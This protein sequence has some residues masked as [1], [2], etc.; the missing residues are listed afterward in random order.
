M[1]RVTLAL[2]FALVAT[3]AFAQREPKNVQVL[4]ELT[5]GQLIRA[6]QFISA[7]LGV[8]CDFCHVRD[9]N[10]E[11]DAANDAK[12]EKKTARQMMHL[13]IDTNEKFFEGKTEVS[14]ET[15]HRGSPGPVSIPALPVSLPPRVAEQPKPAPLPPRDDVVAKYAKALGNVDQKALANVELKGTR[16]TAQGSGQ[17]D[18]VI[19]PGRKYR[20][21]G[22]TAQG[23]TINVV[24][25]ENGWV[26]DAKGTRPM[27]PNQLDTFLGVAEAYGMTL[28]ADIPADARVAGTTK[29]EDR[30]AY[31]MAVRTD[32]VRERLFFDAGT[33]LL[34]RRIRY[35]PTPIGNVPQQTDYSDY[36]D[37]N[38]MKVPFVVRV[39]TIDPRAGA[40][41]RYSEI[42]FNAKT[43][44]NQFE[45]PK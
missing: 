22:T 9:A 10:G 40:T 38:G 34:V 13:V 24:N 31:V 21:T 27:P 12:D 1:K 4:K 37:V 43:S 23:E 17:F 28:P 11:L 29:V 45:E 18:I 32:K 36:R 42:H 2:T 15:C 3:T 19:G 30:D 6:M 35:T 25:G 26:H 39:D 16:D 5:P 20:A 44:E 33:G 14:C 41:R 8:T 7:S